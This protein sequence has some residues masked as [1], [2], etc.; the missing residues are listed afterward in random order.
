MS[1]DRERRSG[2]REIEGGEGEEEDGESGR[3]EHCNDCFVYR[4]GGIK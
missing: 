3:R 1:A 2:R 4:Y